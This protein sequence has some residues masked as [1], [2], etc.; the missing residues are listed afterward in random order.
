MSRI[1]YTLKT[2]CWIPHALTYELKHVRLTKF[3]QLLPKLRAHTH[4]NAPIHNS[5]MVIGKL[6]EQHLK[7]MPHPAYSPDLSP[8]DFFLSG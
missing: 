4:D 7:R 2:L 3:L 8:C 5:K 6:A 1:D